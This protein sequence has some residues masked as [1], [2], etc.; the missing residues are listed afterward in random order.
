MTTLN[1]VPAPV[2]GDEPAGGYRH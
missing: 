2:T 1:S